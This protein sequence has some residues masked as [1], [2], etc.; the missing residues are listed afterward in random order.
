MD[1]VTE[2][3]T[4]VLRRSILKGIGALALSPLCFG[5]KYSICFLIE[6]NCCEKL[7]YQIGFVGNHGRDDVVAWFKPR[8][9]V[10]S[11]GC[12]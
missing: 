6:F 3:E 1:R 12:R 2:S 4:K 9:R 8:Q 10:A 7:Q 5:N 11:F